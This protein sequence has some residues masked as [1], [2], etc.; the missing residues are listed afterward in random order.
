MKNAW[1]SALK[2]LLEPR[3]AGC[4]PIRLVGRRPFWSEADLPFE[5]HGAALAARIVPRAGFRKSSLA[6]TPDELLLIADCPDDEGWIVP[7]PLLAQWMTR[8]VTCE[9]LDDLLLAHPLYESLTR[10]DDAGGSRGGLGRLAGWTPG[11]PALASIR[12]PE[13]MPHDRAAPMVNRDRAAYAAAVADLL[14]QL[15]RAFEPIELEASF[16]WVGK[17]ARPHRS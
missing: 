6:A 3:C 16:R 17:P 15:E 11:I 8:N 1:A 14:A 13:F 4:G 5:F 2:P 7:E 9:A 12:E 10:V